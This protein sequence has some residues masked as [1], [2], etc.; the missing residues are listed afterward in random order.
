MNM[1]YMLTSDGLSV[2]FTGKNT[3]MVANDH[4]RFKEIVEAVQKNDKM[5]YEDFEDMISLKKSIAKLAAEGVEITLNAADQLEVKI[6]GKDVAVLSTPL[7]F[8]L[9]EMLKMSDKTLQAVAYQ[10]FAKF[11]RNLYQN[12]SYKSV[13]QLYGFLDA[14]DLPITQNGTFLAYKKIRSDYKDIH[15]G[16]FDNSVGKTVEMPRN[17]VEDDP[18]KT[19]S[20][21]LHVCSFGY[22]E[23]YG[24]RELGVDRVVVCEVDPKDVVSIPVDYD[25]A[26][27]R[28]CKYKVIDEM[29]THFETR[30]ASYLYGKHELNWMN[31]TFDDLEKLYKKFFAVKSVEFDV[32]P[33]TIEMTPAVVESFYEVAEKALGKIPEKVKEISREKET[34]PTIKV[35]FQWLSKYDTNWK[36]PEAEADDADAADT[37]KAED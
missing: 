12:P 21:G 17:Q 2:T 27:M 14:N 37:E 28:V 35:L 23:N 8:R 34:V 4:P 32:L 16:T 29:S 7:Q 22:L 18:Y 25:N 24:S 13:Q 5:S 3:F 30:I 10:S 11:L 20:A 1:F 9:I 31:K 36:R 19:C 6:D 26:K 33:D 15:S